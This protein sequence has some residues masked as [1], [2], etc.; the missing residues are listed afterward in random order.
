MERFSSLLMLNM[1]SSTTS[2]WPVALV[3]NSEHTFAFARFRCSR[4]S[5]FTKTSP[6]ANSL[7]KFQNLIPQLCRKIRSRQIKALPIL[8]RNLITMIL[9]PIPLARN[10]AMKVELWD[11]SMNDLGE[12]D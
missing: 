5:L 12:T 11:S 6:I 3:E 2:T 10:V 9:K 7:E 4:L 8:H 1:E